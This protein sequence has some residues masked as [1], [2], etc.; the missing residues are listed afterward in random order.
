LES[1]LKSVSARSLY[2]IRKRKEKER[3]TD[4]LVCKTYI[5]AQKSYEVSQKKII[6]VTNAKDLPTLRC[7]L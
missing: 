1:G 6:T 3:V 7:E 2:A 5:E 4:N